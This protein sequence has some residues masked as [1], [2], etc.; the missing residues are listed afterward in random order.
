MLYPDFHEL[1]QLGRRTFESYD[2]SRRSFFSAA[3]GDYTSPFRGQGLDFEEVRKYVPGD[4]IRN[5]DWRVTARTG[6]AHMKVFT[7]ERERTVILCIDAGAH[8]RFGTRGTF[9]SVQ[10][11]RAAAILGWGANRSHDRVGAVI[12]GDVPEGIQFL[13][14]ARSRRPLWKALKLLCDKPV[15]QPDAPSLEAVLK[16]LNRSAPTSALIFIVAGFEAPNGDLEKNLFRLHRRCEI[17]LVRL[18]DPADRT[19]P[20]IGTLHFA[21]NG[22]KLVVDTDSRQGR[23]TYTRQWH[24]SRQLLEKIAARRQIGI[25]DVHTDR[26]IRND[27]MSGLRRLGMR[28]DTQ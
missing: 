16:R 21:G 15:R 11:A 28:R 12:Y 25:I 14:P 17:V 27:L 23:E 22:M 18:N 24:E 1:M 5:I 13:S 19:I 2:L 3:P 9:K 26:D 6:Q 4:D 10:S 8:M 7:E 20:P